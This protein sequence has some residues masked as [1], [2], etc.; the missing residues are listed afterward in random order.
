[1]KKGALDTKRTSVALLVLLLIIFTSIIYGQTLTYDFV[2]D[3]NG[4]HLVQNPYLEKLSFQNLLHF[5]TEPY[6]GMYIPISY[7]AIFVIT[8][9]SKFLTGFPFNTSFFHFFNVLFHCINCILV[10]YFLR[11]ILKNTSAAFIGTLIFLAHPIQAEAVSM[12]TEFRGLFST[13]WGLL[14]FLAA[15]KSLSQIKKNVFDTLLCIVL[16]LFSVLSKPI[17]VVF[18]P[19]FFIYALMFKGLRLEQIIKRSIPYIFISLFVVYI[20][21]L[22]QPAFILK[23]EVPLFSRFFIW[24]DSLVFYLKKIFIP[25]NFSPSYA[26]TTQRVLSSWMPYVIWIIPLIFLILLIAYRKRIKNVSFAYFV[27]II[28]FLPVSGLV[29]FIF[30]NWSTVADR[31]IYISMIG[32]ALLVGAVYRYFSYKPLKF[33]IIALI[34]LLAA[35]TA[36]IQVPVWKNNLTL[37]S[38][39]IEKTPIEANAYYNRGNAFMRLKMYDAANADFE[40]AVTYDTGFTK[41]LYKKGY[42]LLGQKNFDEALEYFNSVLKIDSEFAIAYISKAVVYYYLKEYDKAWDEIRKAQIRGIEVNSHFM[43]TLAKASQEK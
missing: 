40:N 24:M 16:F 20:T 27:F 23:N 42:L 4:P 3:D 37:W 8:L 30:Q 6:Q 2:W 17:G 15:D 41:A 29:P 18:F 5:W 31:Y 25:L 26:R 19:I 11:K 34:A 38:H 36:L 22:F 21:K 43:K 33:L 39:C 1:M 14:F 7:T 10:F 35:D 9:I 28:G 32:M 13:F 12:V